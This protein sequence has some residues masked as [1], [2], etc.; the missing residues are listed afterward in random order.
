MA[1]RYAP[2]NRCADQ[3]TGQIQPPDQKERKKRRRKEKKTCDRGELAPEGGAHSQRSTTT[4]VPIHKSTNNKEPHT[5]R[6]ANLQ[7][8]R[9]HAAT[10]H[11][12]QQRW[13][14]QNEGKTLLSK[15]QWIK[16]S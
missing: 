6:T 4:T 11:V 13:A 5:I 10:K 16:F 14:D 15:A 3:T 2:Q 9:H 8:T 7:K 1:I 12:S